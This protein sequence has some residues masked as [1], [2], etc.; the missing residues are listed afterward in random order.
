MPRIASSAIASPPLCARPPL[1]L[2]LTTPATTTT[3]VTITYVMPNEALFRRITT[4]K[5]TTTYV[6]KHSSYA[7]RGTSPSFTVAR[8]CSSLGNTEG[9]TKEVRDV[10]AVR[11][12]TAVSPVA[13][14][15][16]LF[17]STRL[18]F[19]VFWVF[20][21]TGALVSPHGSPRDLSPAQRRT[22]DFW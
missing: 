7:P 1:G 19:R 14:A 13:R 22:S 20:W 15:F 2:E 18:L 10:R 5:T 8:S 12:A 6:T 9:A 11:A 16:H 17:Q 21:C 3:Y 4:H